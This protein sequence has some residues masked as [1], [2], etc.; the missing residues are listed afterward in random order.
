MSSC[1]CDRFL[2]C[3]GM[4]GALLFNPS[5]GVRCAAP[6]VLWVVPAARCAGLQPSCPPA[7][8]AAL[9]AFPFATVWVLPQR[10]CPAAA[11][12]ARG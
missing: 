12:P 7:V 3:A 8:R 10:R 6:A 5:Q 2:L 4:P 1:A 9:A 11:A